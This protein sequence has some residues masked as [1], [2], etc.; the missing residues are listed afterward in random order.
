VME[1]QRTEAPIVTTNAAAPAGISDKHLLEL[2]SM[3]GNRLSTT[4]LAPVVTPTLE[5]AQQVVGSTLASPPRP[6]NRKRARAAR[7]WPSAG[8]AGVGIRD[9]DH[10]LPCARR[11]SAE[12]VAGCSP[13]LFAICSTLNPRE[14]SCC[15][16]SLSMPVPLR[17]FDRTYVRIDA[18]RKLVLRLP[19]RALRRPRGSPP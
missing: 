15:S 6:A 18:G 7:S 19:F 11:H 13:T 4:A 9:C 12:T 1:G 17:V 14:R 5:G 2:T 10:D 16:D 3:A 8:G